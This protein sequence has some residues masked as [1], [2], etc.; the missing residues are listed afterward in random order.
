MDKAAV[1]KPSRFKLR[2]LIASRAKAN[3]MDVIEA[4]NRVRRKLDMLPGQTDRKYAQL[5]QITG[6][7]PE[8]AT[9]ELVID[10]MLD[11]WWTEIQTLIHPYDREAHQFKPRAIPVR[12]KI[13]KAKEYFAKYEIGSRK[14]FDSLVANPNIHVKEAVFP[15]ITVASDNPNYINRIDREFN[16]FCIE[17]NVFEVI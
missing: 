2:R 16:S 12:R 1:L 3:P 17:S 9:E 4:V 6:V 10:R 13:K 8:T 11:A 5:L 15:Y 7:D 14:E